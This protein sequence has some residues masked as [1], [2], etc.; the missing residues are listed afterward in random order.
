M[1]V[2]VSGRGKRSFYVVRRRQ[3]Q[4]NPSWVLLGHYPV[5]TLGEARA[6]G[7]EVL[8]SLIDGDD[9]AELAKA[10]RR[11]AEAAEQKRQAGT[12]G[13]V[14]ELYIELYI[15][16]H[17][18]A[19]R[20]GREVAAILRQELVP[21]WGGRQ[22]VDIAKR[23]IL[24]LVE[25][26]ADSGGAKAEPGHRRSHGGDHAARKRLAT[27][28]GLFNWCVERDLVPVSPCD[29]IRSAKLLGTAAP[30]D[31]VLDDDELRAVWH[32]ANPED[33]THGALVRLLILTA[34]RRD[35]VASARWREIDLDRG[36]LTVG[37][38]RMKAGAAHSVPLTPT[39]VEI[40]RALPRF[41]T[42]DYVFPGQKTGTPFTGFSKA[43]ARLDATIAKNS[44]AIAA[45]S[46]HDLRRTVRT[47]LSE[48]GV[49]PFVAE[50]VLA[51]Q[52]PGIAKVYDLHRYDA[53][54][55]DALKKWERRLTQIVAPETPA[56]AGRVVPLRRRARG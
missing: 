33:Y 53:E 14:A 4:K 2:R 18:D 41:T 27:I 19:L 35:E 21:L 46:L 13:A 7:R 15:K 30:R 50:L 9:P 40:L 6:K 1:A 23:D 31:R 36:I 16:R 34:C 42:N 54:K 28:R 22:L 25:T 12:F 8:G 47:R 11:A 5:M 52:Q 24:D 3:G 48:L 32:A 10:K 20:S 49:L 29:R 51:H 56:P 37:A 26:V 55:R 44:G 39:A 17:V 43:K 45:F 38:E